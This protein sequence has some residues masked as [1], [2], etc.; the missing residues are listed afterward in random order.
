MQ[1]IFLISYRRVYS[2]FI[3]KDTLEGQRISAVARAL[4]TKLELRFHFLS[5]SFLAKTDRSSSTST[6]SRCMLVESGFLWQEKRTTICEFAYV[7]CENL[8]TFNPLL[9]LLT[10]SRLPH[11]IH[12]PL[13]PALHF[14]LR[15]YPL[16]RPRAQRRRSE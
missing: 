12:P 7:L 15:R 11:R 13:Q 5:F 3:A 9:L 14:D 1:S 6:A 2:C 4:R 10:L 16:L 8:S